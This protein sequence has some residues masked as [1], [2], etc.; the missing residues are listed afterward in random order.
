MKRIQSSLLLLF[1]GLLAYGQDI[2]GTWAGTLSIGP[3]TLRVVFHI[4]PDDNG[5][6]AT[7][8]SPDQGANGIV[9]SHVSYVDNTLILKLKL[10]EL[11]YKGT[12]KG[13]TIIGTA[14]QAGHA[15]PL[16]L[17]RQ[18]VP[19]GP[20]KGKLAGATPSTVPANLTE[21]PVELKTGTGTLYG[22]LTLPNDFQKGPMAL[23]IAGS[24]P[25]DRDGNNPTMRCDTYKLIAHA[26][27]KA[28]IASVRYDKRGIAHSAAAVERESD[29]RFDHYVDDASAWL[30]WAK[31]DKRFSTLTIIG[32]SEGAMIG[33][34]AAGDADKFI[35]IA[36]TGRP[37]YEVLKE[38]LSANPGAFGDQAIQK[39][40][41]LVAGRTVTATSNEEMMLFRP[42]IQP[43]LMSWFKYDPRTVLAAMNTPTLL[44]Q[45]STDL[46]VPIEDAKRLAEAQ[47]DARLVVL[48]GMNHV[49][50]PAPLDR[51]ANLATYNN[52]TLGLAAGLMEAIS[53][54]IVN[55]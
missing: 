30:R 19:D 32:H 9:M 5:F 8:D 49:L 20:D 25:T 46:Q 34:L 1:V 28:G 35:S 39:V 41:S 18:V 42:S 45:G 2:S 14:S 40:D 21:V 16:I 52:P 29:L 12:H 33:M 3:Q 47:P 26:L 38:Q 24:G 51:A 6:S 4:T 22:T 31:Q 17:T 55:K 13:D 50:K 37:A 43:Y 53:D 54:F 36:G 15:F 11:A 48:E 27:A 7:M 44:L 10:A 23:I